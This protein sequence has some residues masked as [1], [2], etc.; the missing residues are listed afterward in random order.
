MGGPQIRSGRGG[1][2]KKS[3]LLPEIEARSS[4]P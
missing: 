2:E 1:E 3:L 4:S